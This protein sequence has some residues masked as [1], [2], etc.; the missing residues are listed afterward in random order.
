MTASPAVP[1]TMPGPVF[2]TGRELKQGALVNTLAVVA[3]NFR[4]IFT[5]LV[6]RLLG[7]ATLGTF[8]VAWATTDLLSKIGVFGLDNAVVALI[9]RSEAA[10]DHLRS[11]RLARLAT[12][13]AVLQC[14]VVAGIFSL[15]VGLAGPVLGLD[16]RIAGA[17]A[18]MLLA[19]PGVALYRVS[20]SVS[21]AMKVMRH[22]IF[23]RGLTETVVTTLAFVGLFALGLTSYAPQVA[24]IAGT[25][26]SGL[27]A[28]LLAASLFRD[29][30]KGNRA[31][32]LAEARGLLAFAAPISVYD[33]LNLLVMRIDVIML[34]AFIGRAPGVTLTVVG[35]YGAVVE[36]A[37]GLRKVNQSFNPIFGPVIARV[38]ARRDHFHAEEAFAT[39]AQWMLWVLLPLVAVL[40]LAGGL[41]LSIYG[42]D[43][44]QGAPWLAIVGL[45]CATNAFVA[46]AETAIMVQRPRANL[47]NSAVTCAVAIGANLWLIPTFGV[48]GAAFG[49]LVPYVVQGLLRYR[50]LRIDF[51]WKR[52]F[53]HVGAPLLAALGA[54][55]PALLVRVRVGGVWG[56]VGGALVFLALFGATWLIYRRVRPLRELAS[57]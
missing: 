9:G 28:A 43:F 1:A 12:A 32:W 15:G 47:L 23:S 31:G 18:I 48:T 33:L 44:I 11:R 46:L 29:Q 37:G 34:A 22:D 8:S 56:E 38:L 54:G 49:I 2:Q 20:T 5:F 35:I 41:I 17:T 53:R 27:V 50:T 26:A 39:V 21:R 55:I 6:A 45:A 13:L 3:S 51:G 10:G 57:A 25:L 24:V 7:P 42:P 40:T 14:A 36:V 4:G 19:L 52:P 30:P 16:P